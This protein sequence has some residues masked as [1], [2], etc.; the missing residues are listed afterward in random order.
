MPTTPDI[1]ARIGNAQATLQA[2]R[3]AHAEAVLAVENGNTEIDLDQLEAELADSE[4]KLARLFTLQRATDAQ[5]TAADQEAQ[6]QHAAKCRQ[7]FDDLGPKL[8]TAA[9]RLVEYLEGLKPLIDE[10]KHLSGERGA[11]LAAV[12]DPIRAHVGPESSSG[13]YE[14]CGMRRGVVPLALLA[15]LYRSGLSAEN[16]ALSHMDWPIHP[17]GHERGFSLGDLQ[18]ILGELIDKSER[19]ISN[20]LAQAHEVARKKTQ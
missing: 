19:D 17:P 8:R 20:G 9:L 12:L 1:L 5:R 15:A 11:A 3:D 4:R 10:F 6:R 7:R 18:L 13:L 2:A 14:A 16:F